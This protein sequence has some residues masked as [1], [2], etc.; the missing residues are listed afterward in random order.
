MHTA[1]YYKY[2]NLL[3]K[4]KE[5]ISAAA[6]DSPEVDALRD[7]MDPLWFQLS[8]SERTGEKRGQATF[9]EARRIRLGF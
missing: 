3:N 7:E 1:A 6:D 9:R 2:V 5:L 4:L 8:E